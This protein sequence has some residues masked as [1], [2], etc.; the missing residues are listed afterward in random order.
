M[1]PLSR[2][3]FHPAKLN[4]QKPAANPGIRCVPSK[5]K[6]MGVRGRMELLGACSLDACR[7]QMG[8]PVAKVAAY[9]ELY[10]TQQGENANYDPRPAK[11]TAV[12]HFGAGLEIWPRYG[13]H[14]SL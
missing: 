7:F 14:T 8:T 4:T 11:Y 12:R 13:T 6:A 3:G 10:A 1:S 5:R 9:L 2:S